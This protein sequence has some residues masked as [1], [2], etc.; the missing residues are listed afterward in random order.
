MQNMP[1]IVRGRE[2]LIVKGVKMVLYFAE[3]IT[4][5]GF[6]MLPAFFDSGQDF[7]AFS[8][9]EAPICEI[10]FQGWKGGDIIN[11][12]SLGCDK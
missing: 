2:V 11:A 9:I 1:L 6:V 3:R 10:E 7:L 8:R 12:D 4:H 5:P